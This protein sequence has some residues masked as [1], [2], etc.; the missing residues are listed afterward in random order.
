MSKPP[1]LATLNG[2]KRERESDT[3]EGKGIEG[4]DKRE[5][6]RGDV[7]VPR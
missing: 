7:K 1:I 5:R 3:K 4:A 6:E 2:F